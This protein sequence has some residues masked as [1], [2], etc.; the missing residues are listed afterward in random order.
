MLSGATELGSDSGSI[1]HF[2]MAW[3]LLALWVHVKGKS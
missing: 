1:A 2:T 3:I